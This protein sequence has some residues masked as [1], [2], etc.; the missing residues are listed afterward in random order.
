MTNNEALRRENK[1]KP[2]YAPIPVA[3]SQV[4]VSPRTIRRMIARGE[5]TGYRLGPRILRVD[6]NE[7]EA[8]LRPIPSA[9]PTRDH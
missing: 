3:A 5:L 2:D 4:K 9:G 8:L 7:L 6:L 1:T